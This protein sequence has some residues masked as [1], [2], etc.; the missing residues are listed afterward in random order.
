MTEVHCGSI[1]CTAY[2]SFSYRFKLESNLSS[3]LASFSRH[4]WGRNNI[5]F[6]HF[7]DKDARRHARNNISAHCHPGPSLLAWL[8][9]QTQ[10][11]MSTLL[12]IERPPGVLSDT[13]VTFWTVCTWKASQPDCQSWKRQWDNR[14]TWRGFVLDKG[15]TDRFPIVLFIFACRADFQMMFYSVSACPFFFEFLALNESWLTLL[16]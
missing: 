7:S 11:I 1:D 15:L 12:G 2:A 10:S 16:L 5:S 3:V 8:N 9:V 4:L 13:C 6:S 14:G